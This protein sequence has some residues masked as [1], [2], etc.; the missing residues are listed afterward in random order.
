MRTKLLGIDVDQYF[1][2]SFTGLDKYVRNIVDNI[3]YSDIDGLLN[4]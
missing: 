3:F 2:T 4:L 1:K